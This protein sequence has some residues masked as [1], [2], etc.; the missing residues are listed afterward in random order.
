MKAIF[1]QMLYEQLHA[2]AHRTEKYI[3]YTHIFKYQVS[4]VWKNETKINHFKMCSAIINVTH[5]LLN[6]IDKKN[7]FSIW[8]VK[9]KKKVQWANWYMTVFRIYPSHHCP[10]QSCTVPAPLYHQNA[11]NEASTTCINKYDKVNIMF[12]IKI[13][14]FTFTYPHWFLLLW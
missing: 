14:A 7:I 9:K 5:N 12:N 6:S 8:E 10:T 3:Q 13:G 2:H 11:T 4:V 1:H